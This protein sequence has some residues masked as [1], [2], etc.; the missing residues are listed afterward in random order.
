[1]VEESGRKRNMFLPPSIQHLFAGGCG[2][3]SLIIVG[4]PLDT[5]KV[6]LQTMPQP[7]PGEKPMFSG[8]WNCALQTV[9]QEGF[10][11]LYRGMLAPLAIS[12]PTAALNFWAFN[13]GKSLQ[14]HSSGAVDSKDLKPHQ[15]FLAG[16]F[17][18]VTS[19][20]FVVPGER[21]KCLL[22]IQ[23]HSKGKNKYKGP[24]D[25]IKHIYREE[26]LRGV[27]RG[28]G[29]G[30]LRDVP[31]LGMFFM[32]YE[33]ILRLITPEGQSR[34]TVGPFAI[35]LAGGLAGVSFWLVALPQDVLKS[36]YQTAPAGMYP[37]GMRDVLQITVRKEGYRALWRGVTPVMI[38]AFPACSAVYLGYEF[39]LRFLHWSVPHL[40][41]FGS[42]IFFD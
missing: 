22:Q 28:T 20:V 17:T 12:M 5:V 30:L 13:K 34:N 7:S 26:G 37:R 33:L 3:A 14:L 35:T 29:V 9:K 21:M 4:H 39:G 2:G 32:S 6:R 18:G 23:R 40:V 11:S 42:G 31:G 24:F 41:D 27:Y 19:Q 8:A 15:I 16:A 36:R 38:R 10:F 25:C 1:M